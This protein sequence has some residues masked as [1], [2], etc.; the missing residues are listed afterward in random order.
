MLWN[1]IW[2]LLAVV[3]FYGWRYPNFIQL[4]SPSSS[5]RS[6]KG[7]IYWCLN[8][9]LAVG[10]FLADHA[11][12]AIRNEVELMPNWSY[13]LTIPVWM[14][15][16]GWRYVLPHLPSYYSCRMTKAAFP[17]S[18]NKWKFVLEIKILLWNLIKISNFFE[19]GCAGCKSQSHF[20]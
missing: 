3:P 8:S 15:A 5:P 9:I 2:C 6:K 18:I 14:V 16:I 7:H 13:C 17:A 19:C 10:M 20:L 12:K 4:S 1:L 11:A